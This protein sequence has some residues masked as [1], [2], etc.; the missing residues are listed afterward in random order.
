MNILLIGSGGR[1]HALAWAISDSPLC[2]RLVIT[3]GNPGAAA[4]GK[5][6]NVAA[7]DIDGLVTLAKTEAA[8][9]VVI[10]PEVPLVEG[11]SDRLEQKELGLLA[12]LRQQPSLRAQNALDA[13]FVTV[14]ISRSRNG[15]ILRMRTQQRRLQARLQAVVW[16]RQMGWPQVKG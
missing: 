14:T 10:G 15:T 5:L 6:A 1:E 9:I 7:D 13:N 2:D 16:S 3:P 11:L 12:H 8:D 4:F